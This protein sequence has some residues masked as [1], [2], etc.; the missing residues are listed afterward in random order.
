MKDHQIDRIKSAMIL[1]ALEE[2]LGNYIILNAD[3]NDRG[4]KNLNSS[5][6]S[7][8]SS[9]KMIVEK[10]YLDDVFSLAMKHS[11]GSSEEEKVKE[12]KKFCE[13]LK[14]FDIRNAISHPNRPFHKSYWFR[15]AAIASDP[16]I[17]QLRLKDVS[18]AL[19]AAMDDNIT[20]PPEDWMDKVTWEIPNSLPAS[21]DHEITGLLGRTKD[22]EELRSTL[23]KARSTLI[24]LVAPGGI[25]KTALILQFLRDISLEP[26]WNSKINCILFCS[27]K[28]EKL[29]DNGVEKITAIDGIEDVKESILSD[30]KGIYDLDDSLSFEEVC[31]KLVDQ[32]VLICI[33]NLETLLVRSQEEFNG[34]NQ[35]L[36]LQWRVIVTS[37]I[38]LDSATTVSLKPL[39]RQDAYRLCRKYLSKRGIAKFEQTIIQEICEKAHY[40]PLAIRFTSDLI[41]KGESIPRA[42]SKSEKEITTFSYSNLVDSLTEISMEVLEALYHSGS[43]N[44]EF[45]AEILDKPQDDITEALNELTKTSLIFRTTTDDNLDYFELSNSIKDLLLTNPRNV[46]IREKIALQ[47]KFKKLKNRAQQ[48]RNEKYGLNKFD[49]EYVSDSTNSNI[50][51][52]IIDLNRSLRKGK[53]QVQPLLDLKQKFESLLE[54]N[55]QNA[56][57]LFHY[58]RIFKFLKDW[59]GELQ[60]IQKAIRLDDQ[61]PKFIL[62]KGVN[63]HINNNYKEAEKDFEKLIDLEYDHP[64]NS[65]ESF[66]RSLAHFYLKNLLSQHKNTEIL[67]ITEDWVNHPWPEIYGTFRATACFYLGSSIDGD[68]ESKYLTILEI[69]QQLFEKQNY[70]FTGC[71][72]GLII[73]R[74]LRSIVTQADKYSPNLIRKYLYFVS[75][76]FFE[77][78]SKIHWE[79][80]ESSDN[81]DFLNTLYQF[82]LEDIENPLLNIDWYNPKGTFDFE[83]IEELQEQGFTIVTVYAPPGGHRNFCFAEDEDGYQYYLNEQKAP[84]R[85]N[86]W[87]NIKEGDKFAI[88][89]DKRTDPE[90]TPATQIVRIEQDR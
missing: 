72:E 25:G 64:Q 62:A 19:K 16:L 58:S 13:F 5:I 76:H 29:T 6:T 74:R 23:G 67:D 77:M 82:S 15:S 65:S 50:K 43:S 31:A 78:V 37:R 69:Y 70:P 51:S 28:N 59:T 42:I 9:I 54:Y 26:Q 46:E 57:L 27:L 20:S 1:H 18:V 88:Q 7:D 44:R 61:N 85:W 49:E 83:Q 32:R 24:A 60:L 21:F 2:A 39:N 17:E 81:Q 53:S 84:D 33:D 34:F 35:S 68:S 75:D 10:S 30:L 56:D 47:K 3:N 80:I 55:N 71:K 4:I 41:V 79:D 52:L 63:E 90:A 11:K 40:N 89:Y 12:L 8:S 14:I 38:S 87:V 22:E 86:G 73:I 48:R 66:S 36:P 45:I